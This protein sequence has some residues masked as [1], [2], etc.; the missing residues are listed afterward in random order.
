ML[1]VEELFEKAEDFQRWAK[2]RVDIDIWQALYGVLCEMIYHGGVNVEYNG[3]VYWV[4]TTMD[5]IK[6]LLD[7]YHF[8]TTRR[9]HLL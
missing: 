1:K 3:K 9:L 5:A 7:I 8:F 2:H 6:L 4:R